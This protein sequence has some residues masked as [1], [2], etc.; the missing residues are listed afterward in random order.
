MRPEKERRGGVNLIK[1]EDM[2]ARKL[3]H[4]VES[5]K[6]D[7]RGRVVTRSFASGQTITYAYN[8]FDKVT[9]ITDSSGPTISMTYDVMN[10][11]LTRSVTSGGSTQTRSFVWDDRDRLIQLTE[12]GNKI[13]RYEYDRVAVGCNVVDKPSRIIE[14]GNKVTAM[15]Y[16][17][18]L[19]LTRLTNPKGEVTRR[20]YNLRGDLIAI[21]DA[22]NHRT[23]MFWDGNGRLIREERP[24]SAGSGTAVTEISRYFY[25]GADRLVK[26]EKTSTA[27]GAATATI[28]LGY[29]DFDRVVSKVTKRVAANGAVTIEDSSNYNYAAQLDAVLR[30]QAVNGV[31]DQ[32]F[33]HEAVPPFALTSFSQQAVQ[34]GNPWGIPVG[35]FNVS[36]DV[37]GEIGGINWNGTDLYSAQY[38]AAARLTRVLS[39]YAG[40]NL[41]LNM[42]FDGFGRKTSQTSSTGLSGSWTYDALNRVTNIN[43]SGNDG[44]VAQSITEALV[45][46]VAGNITSITRDGNVFTFTHDLT[47]QLTSVNGPAS[48]GNLVDNRSWSFD[49]VGNRTNDSV[50]GAGASVNNVITQLGGRS[51]QSDNDGWSN[52]TRISG[53]Q[54]SIGDSRFSY[55]ADGQITAFTKSIGSGGSR[56][57]TN[58][59]YAIDA[60]GRRIARS[61]ARTS[62][63]TVNQAYAFLG[64]ED[65]V[66]LGRRGDNVVQLFI[67]GKGVDEHLAQID[68]GALKVYVT[69]HLGSTLNSIAA[70]TAK[71]YT[72]WGELLIAA[73]VLTNTTDAVVYGLTGCTYNLESST[74]TCGLREL[75]PTSGGWLQPDML[76]FGAGQM[77]LR[78]YAHNSPLRFV[79]PLGLADQQVCEDPAITAKRNKALRDILIGGLF[80][81]GGVLSTPYVGPIGILPIVIGGVIVVKGG[82]D[83][84]DA[85]A[86][87]AKKALE[88]PKPQAQDST[89]P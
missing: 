36:R 32:G 40:Q 79:D 51:Y 89:V 31:A 47:D 23:Q 78:V 33:T 38:D 60:L 22:E 75:D 7:G 9:Q 4:A 15:E 28:E 57:D 85:N 84:S 70:G 34:A 42:G 66:L 1:Y 56:V 45:Y 6:Y 65:K 86:E 16:D 41:Q 48:L 44:A 46:D 13:T 74:Y 87:A 81:A 11:M 17:S 25:D 12:P 63:G 58:A 72:P 2:G 24:S 49:G 80:V 76:G 14:S 55:R 21:T 39:S 29:D 50:L 19:R 10:R 83:L 77:N 67:D 88:P 71:Q 18:R 61:V 3:E 59:T 73:P 5:A 43:W 26:Q 62:G 69:D 53:N 82:S 30:T 68:S 27:S 20:E 54:N 64:E 37:T 8:D 35:T 52:I